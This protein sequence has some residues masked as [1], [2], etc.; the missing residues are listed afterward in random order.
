MTELVNGIRGH[1]NAQPASARNPHKAHMDR[2]MRE[3]GYRQEKI[4]HHRGVFAKHD[5]DK[6]GRLQEGEMYGFIKELWGLD[7]RGFSS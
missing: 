6:D 4:N 1:W 2:F 7:D 5:K 3:A